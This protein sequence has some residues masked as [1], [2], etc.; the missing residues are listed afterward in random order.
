MGVDSGAYDTVLV[1]HILCV[2]IGFGGVM[3]NGIYGV[4]SKR[5]PGPEGLA[6]FEATERVSRVA[7]YFIWA[8]PVFGIA[9][10]LMSHSQWTF[11]QTWV[12][13]S[14]VIYAL[15][16]TMVLTLHLPNLRRMGHLM[17]E[18]IE[19]GSAPK[20]ASGGAVGSDDPEAAAAITASSEP[21]AQVAKLAACGKLAG[22]CGGTLN[23]AVVAVV[24]L[25]VWKPGS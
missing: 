7:E 25:M 15:A 14:L 19:L 16:L 3:L 1:L 17:R 5:R 22:I 21:P 12:V 2:V 10:I 4:E 6:V 18:L 8:V 23:L 11:S 24:I 20:V 13:A 9:L